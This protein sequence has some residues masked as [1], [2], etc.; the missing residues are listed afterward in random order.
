M[1]RLNADSRLIIAAQALRAAGYGFTS[2]LL[3]ALFAARDYSALLDGVLLGCIVAGTALG[4]LVFCAAG[5]LIL[6]VTH[7]AQNGLHT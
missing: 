7:C 2:V 5:P 3:G 4:S 6:G 1:P